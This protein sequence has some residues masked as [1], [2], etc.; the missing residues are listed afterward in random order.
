MFGGGWSWLLQIETQTL[1]VHS[2][3]HAVPRTQGPGQKDTK[4]ATNL[5]LTRNPHHK[6]N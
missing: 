4:T 2:G 3:T 1:A 5:S 6:L